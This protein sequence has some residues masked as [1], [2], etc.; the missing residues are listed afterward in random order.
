[1]STQDEWNTK[2][3]YEM[4]HKHSANI[5]TSKDITVIG[6]AIIDVL[7]GSVSEKVFQTGSQLMKKMKLSFGGDALNE[8][9][10]LTRLG[11]H[12]ELVTKIGRDESGTQILNYMKKNG[13]SLDSIRVESGVETAINIVLIDDVGERY[14]LSNPEGSHRKLTETDIAP[15]I[16]AA[17][18]IVSFASMFISPLIDISAMM[19]TF[20]HIKEKPGR[21]LVV[22]MTKVKHGERL[23]DLKCLLPYVDYLLPNETEIA[24]LTGEA[25]PYVNAEL[26]V[27]AGVY[28]AVIKC[29]SRGCLIRTMDEVIQIPA[30]PVEHPID[31]TGAGDCFA[32]G[33]LWGLSEG[34]SLVDCGRFACATASCSVEYMGATEGVNSIEKPRKRYQKLCAL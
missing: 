18:D 6:P 12:V 32:A 22:D 30:Y 8:S 11:K 14:F 7:A 19:R 28:C 34:L 17:A 10:V 26:L 15:Y 20:K 13:L 9:V 29:G 3:T 5:K 24:M 33:F 25:D 23:D 1:M 21:T 31:T 4:Q 2:D 16:D 27:K